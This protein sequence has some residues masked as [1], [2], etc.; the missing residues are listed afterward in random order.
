M[1]TIYQGETLTFTL[2]EEE[3]VEGTPQINAE[4]LNDYEVRASL[5]PAG[6]TFRRDCTCG[7]AVLTW[8]KIDI[9]EGVAEWTLTTE[10]SASLPVGKYA[11]EVALRDIASKQD[12]KDS[13]KSAI[14]E[15]KPSYTR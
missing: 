3:L 13:T 4:A 2:G 10:Q 6:T 12:V 8:E 14:I 7:N 1:I 9:I 15:V 5:F 11:I